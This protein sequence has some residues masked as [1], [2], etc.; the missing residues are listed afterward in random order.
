MLYLRSQKKDPGQG[1]NIFLLSICLETVRNISFANCP[2]VACDF[3]KESSAKVTYMVYI[4]AIGQEMFIVFLISELHA[5]S[6]F[7][8]YKIR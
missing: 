6:H 8:S 4:T 5:A 1:L 2:V 7:V 3:D